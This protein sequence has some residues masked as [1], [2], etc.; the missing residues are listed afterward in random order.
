MTGVRLNRR[1]ERGAQ[2][3]ARTIAVVSENLMDITNADNVEIRIS[4]DGKIVWV[5][6]NGGEYQFR[7]CQI[8]KLN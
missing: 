2:K 6:V 4:D 5:N 7:S 3:V 8:E 1:N